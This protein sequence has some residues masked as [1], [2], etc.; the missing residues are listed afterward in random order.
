MIVTPQ[1]VEGALADLI[2]TR[3]D[4]EDRRALDSAAASDRKHAAELYGLKATPA[5]QRAELRTLLDNSV[6]KALKLRD[7]ATDPVTRSK[8][9][10]EAGQLS[11][12]SA[13]L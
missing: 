4:V 13:N 6:R 3:R 5:Y 10:D 1:E 9:Q 2:Q 8:F 12:L 11:S 7:A